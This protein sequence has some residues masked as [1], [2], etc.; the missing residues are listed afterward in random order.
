[1]PGKLSSLL[2][3]ESLPRLSEDDAKLERWLSNLLLVIGDFAGSVSDALFNNQ[4][5]NNGSATISDAA[6]SVVVTLLFEMPDTDYRVM[7]TPVSATGTPAA[8]SRRVTSVV[9]ARGTIT[10]GIEAVPGAGNSV[11][12]DWMVIK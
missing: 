3:F 10:I 11:T 1:M 8:G 9:K 12:F 7:V 5:W 6:A 4:I 2:P